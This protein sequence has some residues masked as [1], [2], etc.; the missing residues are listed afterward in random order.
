MVDEL[1]SMVGVDEEIP[2]EGRPNK[3]CFIFESILNP[4]LPVAVIWAI[5]DSTFL[6][7]GIESR[8]MIMLPF[9][10]LHMMPVWIYLAGVI[11]SFKKYNYTT[12]K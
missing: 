9:M 7:V 4:L 12:I 10:L 5:L 2:Y 8:N 6:K 3:K 1:K 11:F